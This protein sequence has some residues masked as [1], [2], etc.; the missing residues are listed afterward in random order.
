MSSKNFDVEYLAELARIK[1][2]PDE[3]KRFEAQLGLVLEHVAKLNAIDVLQVEPMAHSFPI[4][5]VFREDEMGES[6]DREA[7]LAN[8]P[9]QAQGLFI[10][11]KVV[12]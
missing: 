8:A 2:T 6:L 12:E 10:V 11:T 4:Y 7:A 9:K 5:N 3:I 1:L